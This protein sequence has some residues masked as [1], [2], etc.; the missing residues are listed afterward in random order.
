MKKHDE[1]NRERS[2]IE[3]IKYCRGNNNGY[4]LYLIIFQNE[5]ATANTSVR[6]IV[7]YVIVTRRYLTL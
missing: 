5:T 2:H 1:E 6:V 7:T 4:S 3:D